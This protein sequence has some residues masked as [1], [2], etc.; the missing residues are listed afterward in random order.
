MPQVYI[1]RGPD[2][3]TGTMD[4]SVVR[5]PILMAIVNSYEKQAI[6]NF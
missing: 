2:T 6:R 4:T 5:D 1:K 3:C